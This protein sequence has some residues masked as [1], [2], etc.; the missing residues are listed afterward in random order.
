MGILNVTPDSFSDGGQYFSLDAALAHARAMVAAGATLIDVGG[1]STRPGAQS[2]PIS[3]EL[4]RVIPIIEAIHA[5]LDCV[6]S[7]DSSKPEVMR[8]AVQ[9]GAGLI[10]DVN[11]LRADG[12]IQAVVETGAAVCVMH[13]QGTPRS[14]QQAPH[15]AD[16]VTEV[17][18]FLARQAQELQV[19]GVPP[20][21][22][23][24]DPGFGFGKTLAHNVALFRAL[25][26]LAAMGYPVLVGVSR[27]SMLGALLGDRPIAGR[28]TASVVAALLAAQA[29]AR[30]L[31]VHDVAETADALA[32][33]RACGLWDKVDRVV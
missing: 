25:P 6:V 8:A 7:I 33:W 20:E 5:E 32:I 18:A 29:G 15:Y 3:E 22:I 30:I 10:N 11:G 16:V 12:S 4:D 19:A 23:V 24:L 26:A 27:K 9:A 13:M 21:R 31:R 14:M 2:V 17:H 1:E 28:Q